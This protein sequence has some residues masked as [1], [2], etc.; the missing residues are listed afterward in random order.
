MAAERHE[1]NMS[2]NSAYVNVLLSSNVR[3]NQ[4][5]RVQFEDIWLLADIFIHQRLREARL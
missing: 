1:R 2:I 5:L 4:I 3:L